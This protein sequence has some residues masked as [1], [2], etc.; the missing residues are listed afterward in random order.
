MAARAA[1][2]AADQ[3]ILDLEDSVA[4]SAKESARAAVIEAIRSLDW[5]DKILAFRPNGFSTEWAYRDIIE[6][7][8]GAGDRLDV[9][10]IPKAN[11]PEEIHYAD[12]LLTQIE[13]R[14]RRRGR[15]R[16]EALIESAPAVL[17]AH[18]IARASDRMESLCFGIGDYA[19]DV[20][21]RDIMDEQFGW[22]L[23]PKH[24][25]LVAAR[26][27]G[28]DA[29]DNITLDVRNP[30]A[31]RA[32]AQ[33]SARLGFDGKWAIHPAQVGPINDAF[34]PTAA[35]VA[36]A[37]R[38][39]DAYARAGAEAGRGAITDGADMVDAATVRIEARKLAVA[40]KAG[41]L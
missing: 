23:F 13:A 18:E 37:Q 40:R 17:R 20:G 19:G 15:I 34:T 35:E 6:V 26:A 38:Y 29:I 36:A 31:A 1:A 2:S 14:L 32:D 4:P 30:E 7:V 12:L 28:I 22:F 27:A 5:G 9:M 16:L 21:A 3:V 8:E 11:G 24:Q 10:V 25:V 39:V 41:L 33:R